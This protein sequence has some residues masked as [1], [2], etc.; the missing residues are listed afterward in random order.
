MRIKVKIPAGIKEGQTF[1]VSKG[2]LFDRLSLH[3]PSMPLSQFI[4]LET[5]QLYFISWFAK[6]RI[7]P[8][9][10]VNVKCPKGYSGKQFLE[11]DIPDVPEEQKQAAQKMLQQAGPG[12]GFATFYPIYIDANKSLAQGRRVPLSCA[13]KLCSMVVLSDNF[14]WIYTP[15]PCC[16]YAKLLLRSASRDWHGSSC[17]QLD[18]TQ[19]CDWSQ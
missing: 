17:P 7:S 19:I 6:V 8:S 13:C 16:W 1:T 3:V 5:L 12:S 18:E 4:L 11:I 15:V 9:H 14:G 10:A 2:Q